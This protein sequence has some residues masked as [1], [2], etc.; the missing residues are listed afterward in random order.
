MREQTPGI[1]PPRTGLWAT[2]NLG[3]SFPEVLLTGAGM[4]P[5]ALVQE[6]GQL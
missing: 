5:N 2:D 1:A 4:P 3:E 6:C